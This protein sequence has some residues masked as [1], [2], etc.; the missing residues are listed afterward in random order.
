M[1]ASAWKGWGWRRGS[2]GEEEEGDAVFVLLEAALIVPPL[3]SALRFGPFDGMMVEFR[4]GFWW[5][6][7]R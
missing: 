1:E 5:R 2:D 3:A 6:M 7:D 4:E